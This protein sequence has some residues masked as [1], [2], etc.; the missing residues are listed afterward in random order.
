M[1]QLPPGYTD[2]PVT[3][4]ACG[5]AHKDDGVWYIFCRPADARGQSFSQQLAHLNSSL[6]KLSRLN[7]KP[8]NND[9]LVFYMEA[10]KPFLSWKTKPHIK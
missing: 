3:G 10:V 5:G 7:S 1:V 2:R 9:N 4:S 8:E 6:K